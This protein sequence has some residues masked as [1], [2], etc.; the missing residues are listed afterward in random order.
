MKNEPLDAVPLGLLFVVVC[1]VAGLALES[2]Y[3]LGRWRHSLSSEEKESPIGAMVGS[4]LAL[5]AFM[6]AFTFGMAGGRFE[7]RRAVVLEEANAIGTTYLRTQLLPEPQRSASAR[8]LKEYVDVRLRGVQEGKIEEAIARS[9]KLHELLWVEAIQAA[10]KAPG[11]ITGL[12]IQSLNETIDLHSKRIQVGLHNRIPISIWIGLFT[13][14][15]LS[16]ASVGY[17]AGLA[18]TRRS[19]AMLGLVL[20]FAGVLFL[21]ADLDRA[22]DGLLKVSQ[23]AMI[24]LQRTL[25]TEKR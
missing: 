16:M 19:P 4:I 5:F 12:Y 20:A 21:I 10:E 13:L 23:Q 24:D 18:A 3:R 8:L 6:L 1:V 7:S 15:L 9:E 22:H 2:G 17:Q 11:P 25:H 14:A